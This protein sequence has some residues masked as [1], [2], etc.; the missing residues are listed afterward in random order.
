MGREEPFLRLARR[1]VL[2]AKATKGGY[3]TNP[4]STDCEV[5]ALAADKVIDGTSVID[6]VHRDNIRLIS[7]DII[8]VKRVRISASP[9]FTN[10]LTAPDRF[11]NLV[12]KQRP[13]I[14]KTDR[15]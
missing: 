1:S 14:P 6:G 5:G 13:V 10:P 7:P 4:R 8:S 15:L 3:L 2:A 11:A 12:D 9:D